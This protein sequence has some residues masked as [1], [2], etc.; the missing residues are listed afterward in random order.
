MKNITIPNWLALGI[1]FI[2]ATLFVFLFSS[3][4]SPLYEHYPF[5]FHGDSG[6]FQ[7]MGVCLLQGGTPYVDLFDHKGP[8]LWFIQA[9]S[10]WIS[11]KCGLMLVQSIFLF[12]TLIVW[13]KSTLLLTERQIPSIITTIFGLLFLLAFYERGNMCEEWSLPFISFPIY[14]YLKRWKSEPYSKQPIFDH[15]DTFIMGLCVGILAMIRL[16]NTAPIIG[17]A[18]W[19]FIRCIQQKEYRRMWIDVILI[20]GGMAI[21]FV[22]CATFYLIKAG[23][24]GVYEMIYGTFIFNF[25]YMNG[26]GTRYDFITKMQFYIPIIGFFLISIIFYFKNKKFVDISVPIFF[27]YIAT[28]F[29]IGR[30]YYGHYLIICVP[31]FILST[32]FIYDSSLKKSIITYIILCCIIIECSRVSIGPLDLLV[33]RFTKTPPHTERHE[34]F[35]R[36]VTSLPEEEQHSIYNA[37]LNHMGHGLFADENIF[38]CNRIINKD[39]IGI[40]SH[41]CEYEAT[42]GIKDLQPIWVLTQSPRPDANDEYLAIHYT[43]ADSIPGGEFDPIWCWKRNDELYSLEPH[44]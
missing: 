2:V 8:I 30:F 4:T 9:F 43:L 24:T 40:S 13:Y 28:L 11:P 31:L 41:L 29:A 5:W 25:L 12:F 26:I 18:L 34:G 42:H 23:W 10:I 15:T 38:Q 16:N 27:S 19:H 6:I 35:H 21:I 17:F 3:T 22:F 7:E 1:L 37:E 14:L 36:F 39:H 20:I 33:Y 44:E 32:C